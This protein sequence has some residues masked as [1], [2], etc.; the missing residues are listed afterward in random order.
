MRNIHLGDGVLAD[1]IMDR[2]V[3]NAYNIDCGVINM[4]EYLNNPSGVKMTKLP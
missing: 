2:I 3:H 1:A 4:R